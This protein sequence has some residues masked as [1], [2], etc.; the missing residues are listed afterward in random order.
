MANNIT[1]LVSQLGT[2]SMKA[3]GLTSALKLMGKQLMGPLGI[4]FAI[5]AA[6][7]ALDFFFGANKKAEKCWRLD[8]KVY[9]SGLVMRGSTVRVVEEYMLKKEEL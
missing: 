6:V 2:A 9:A 4:V 8:K 7:S 3:G 1:Q 5:T